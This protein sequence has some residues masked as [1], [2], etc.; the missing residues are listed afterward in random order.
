MLNAN[1]EFK[2]PLTATPA[3]DDQN[4]FLTTTPCALVLECSNQTVIQLE[5]KGLLKAVKTATGMRLF[6]RLDVERLKRERD[7][8]KRS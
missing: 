3:T 1:D 6:R 2:K 5:R 8:A 7:Q 4:E